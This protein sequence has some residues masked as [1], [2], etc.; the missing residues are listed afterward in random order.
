VEFKLS[1]PNRAAHRFSGLQE[2]RRRS[3]DAHHAGAVEQLIIALMRIS[4]A[5]LRSFRNHLRNGVR[6]RCTRQRAA[7]E[8]GQGKT[9]ALEALSFLCLTKSF[10]ASSDATVMQQQQAF[11]EIKSVTG[12]RTKGKEFQVRVALRRHQEREEVHHQRCIEAEKF[13]SVIG[14]FPRGDPLPREQPITFGS[15]ADRRKFIDPG[16]LPEQQSRTWRIRSNTAVSSASVT[17]C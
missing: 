12:V 3:A 15:P 9:N 7:G 14:M 6:F 2:R 17:R 16:D 4:N 10:Y 5:H 11:F 13:S 1:S 8:N